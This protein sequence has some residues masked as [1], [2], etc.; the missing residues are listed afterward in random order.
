M[1]QGDRN[2]SQ[3]A[4]N[5]LRS[6]TERIAAG[7]AADLS[8]AA[9]LDL[10][11]LAHELEQTQF[12]LELAQAEL[13]AKD[14]QLQQ[15][16]RELEAAGRE[17]LDIEQFIPVGL[18]VLDKKGIVVKANAA[19]RQLLAGDITPLIGRAFSDFVAPEDFSVYLH[20]IKTKLSPFDPKRFAS[21]ELRMKD[22]LGRRFHTYGQ[23]STRYDLQK[24]FSGWQLAF[25]DGS[26]QK[27]IEEELR[28]SREHLALAT[29]AGS[30]GI[31]VTDLDA[32]LSHW[33]EQL[34]RILGLEP[35]N[36]PEERRVFLNRV[37]P[38]DL[39]RYL[40]GI[41]A[42]AQSGDKLE[43]EFRIIRADDGQVRWLTSRGTI[44]RD[45]RGRA[46]RIQ[47]ATWDITDRK[48]AE[49]MVRRAQ[50][51]MAEQLAQTERINEELSQF[52]YA[53]TH[54]LK[55]PLRAIANY[56]QFLNEDLGGTLTGEQ[57]KYLEGLKTAAAQ[58]DALIN[59]LLSFS[60]LGRT[61]P[62]AEAID[63]PVLVHEIRSLLNVPSDVELDVQPQWPK[64]WID[65]TLLKQILQNLIANGLKFNRRNPKRIAIGWQKTPDGRIEIFVRDNGIGIAPDYHEKIFQIFRRLHTSREYE[66]TGIGL[67][68]VQKA[69]QNLGGSIRLE[70]ATGNGST[71]YVNLPDSILQAEKDPPPRQL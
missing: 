40:A 50:H 29:A 59:D 47:G 8:E 12:E 16:S 6:L 1:S 21:F 46:V 69:A 61:P 26:E 66:G 22:H 31:W 27:R 70:S 39:Q 2:S 20:Q 54:D 17:Y 45:Q 13:A 51:Q 60:R 63:V 19:A 7:H 52:T 42:A 67:A 43:R 9:Q 3:A 33:N 15:I 71:F 64:I 11:R 41:E 49:E 57:K 5:A 23:V 37:H 24:Q 35:H 65:Y 10:L 30:I 32:G 38:D 4:R 58:G 62:V 34:Y 48:A 68:I 25:F 36:G 18:M 14:E 28:V 55:A 53:V 44:E 56:A